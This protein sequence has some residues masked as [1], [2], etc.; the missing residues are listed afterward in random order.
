[1][2]ETLSIMGCLPDFTSLPTGA[3][4][5]WHQTTWNIW[6]ISH[7]QYGSEHDGHVG[8]GWCLSS[9]GGVHGATGRPDPLLVIT[10]ITHCDNP[11][12]TLAHWIFLCFLDLF[13][14]IVCCSYGKHLFRCNFSCYATRIPSCAA[15]A[16]QPGFFKPWTPG[17]QAMAAMNNMAMNNMAMMGCG[18]ADSV[19]CWKMLEDGFWGTQKIHRHNSG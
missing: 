3:G 5:L 1:M 16:W 19:R 11:S 2:V 13:L 15:W 14:M 18:W 6:N 7:E 17:M 4:F 10:V 12:K 9:N 8:N